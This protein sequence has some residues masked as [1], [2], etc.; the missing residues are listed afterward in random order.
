MQ[1]GIVETE[2]LEDVRRFIELHE[3]TQATKDGIYERIASRWEGEIVVDVVTPIRERYPRKADHIL[4]SALRGL[5]SAAFYADE[6]ARA[7]ST[8]TRRAAEIED[9]A[10]DALE[11]LRK[12]LDEHSRLVW[13]G[14][15][16]G[17][18]P[19]LG[20]VIEAVVRIEPAWALVTGVKQT[21]AALATTSQ[22]APTF[23]DFIEKAIDLWRLDYSKGQPSRGDARSKFAHE[24]L[25]ILKGISELSHRARAVLINVAEDKQQHT[26]D[27]I[28]T[29]IA[30]RRAQNKG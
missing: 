16:A 13:E 7:K 26:T 20:E 8:G 11:K 29:L 6:L 1:R 21:M 30:R 12:L 14:A 15:D 2:L 27:S 25:D 19:D 23:L 28:K 24:A 5:V 18:P 10:F 22:A 9:E 3:H 17:N 4:Q